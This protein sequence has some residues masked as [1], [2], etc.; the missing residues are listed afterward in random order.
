MQEVKSKTSDVQT[1]TQR[2]QLQ[3]PK[4]EFAKLVLTRIESAIMDVLRV[5]RSLESLCEELDSDYSRA[6]VLE[7]VHALIEKG[8]AALVCIAYAWGVEFELV[9]TNHVATGLR[10]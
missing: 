5:Q 6:E 2:E 3:I 8:S 1:A 9:A 7:S 4:R 10:D